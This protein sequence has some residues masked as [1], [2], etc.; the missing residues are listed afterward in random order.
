MKQ[1]KGRKLKKKRRQTHGET[2][3][4]RIRELGKLQFT[5]L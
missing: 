1:V 2:A 3:I 5:G 4:L